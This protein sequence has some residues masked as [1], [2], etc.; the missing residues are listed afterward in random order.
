[1]IG[2]GGVVGRGEQP[3]RRKLRIIARVVE[4]PSICSAEEGGSMSERRV[5]GIS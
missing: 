5:G 4:G 1:M 2:W 3:D